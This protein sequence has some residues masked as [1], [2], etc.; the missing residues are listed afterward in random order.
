MKLFIKRGCAYCD[1]F[2]VYSE[3][4]EIVCT[5]EV[6]AN[7]SIQIFLRDS[8]S[9][10]LSS[11]RYNTFVLNYFS[12]R[13]GKRMY[14]LVPC[15]GRHFAFAIYGSTFRFTGSLADGSFSMLNSGGETIMTQN[16]CWTSHGEG[17]ELNISEDKYAVFMISVALCA[18]I[19][20][21]LSESDPVPT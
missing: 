9:A 5:A 8:S 17:Y 2:T 13:C 16:K 19:F 14:V 1:G 12:I 10:L 18:D 6:K 3:K 4:G 20:L 21:A 15:V 7:T 11:M